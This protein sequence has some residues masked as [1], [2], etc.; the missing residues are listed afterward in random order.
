MIHGKRVLLRAIESSDLESLAAW[1]NDPVVSH[2]VGG[3]SFP[4]SL[5]EQRDWYE[6]AKSDKS[7]VRMI[8]TA[9]ETGEAIGLTGLWGI[10]WINRNALTAI[11]I[12]P[13][14][15]RGQGYGR[16]TLMTLMSYAFFQVG[17]NRLR[18]DIIE[19]NISSYRLFV[20]K[21]G[22][23]VEGV[24][25]EDAFRDGKYFDR[26]LVACLRS[27]FV[28][29]PDVLDYAPQVEVNRIVITRTDWAGIEPGAVTG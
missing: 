14:A 5:S 28:K 24:A 17:L 20:S 4:I 27:D 9:R 18:S 29:L 22:W 26:I 11:K 15:A 6:R 10:D 23:R 1:L 7:T 19:Y 13:A 3:F 12:G 16:D 21:C 2:L 25:R 8:I